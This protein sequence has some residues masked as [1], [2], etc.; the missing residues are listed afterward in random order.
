MTKLQ[1]QHMSKAA[2]L[3]SKGQ[4]TIPAEVREDLGVVAGD[5]LVFER[6]ADG[7][8][9]ISPRKFQSLLELAQKNP[10]R[11]RVRVGD[12]DAFI[13]RSTTAAAVTRD[14]RSKRKPKA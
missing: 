3:T 12:L 5:K 10:I 13:N 1:G 14:R 8:Y 6:S 2:T 9:R 11:S 7:S 4:I